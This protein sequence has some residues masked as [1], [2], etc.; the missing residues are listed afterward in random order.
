MGNKNKSQ[1]L[2]RRRSSWLALS[3]IIFTVSG[4]GVADLK[5][6]NLT[7]M[8]FP[9]LGLGNT[10]NSANPNEPN[11]DLIA[12]NLVHTL[13][14]LPSL[15]PL[16]TVVQMQPSSSEFDLQTKLALANRG[17]Q[18]DPV[19]GSDDEFVVTTE[20]QNSS[21]ATGRYQLYTVN[22]GEVS[23][24]RAYEVVEGL[25]VPVSAQLVT[26]TTE[27]AISINDDIFESPDNRLTAVDFQS[28]DAPD[29]P[30]AVKVAAVTAKTPEPL[31]V[32]AEPPAVMWRLQLPIQTCRIC[33]LPRR[34]VCKNRICT[35][36]ANPIMWMCSMAMKMS[37]RAS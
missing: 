14:Q 20:I 16:V 21:T 6:P 30:E 19:S 11:S 15:N 7:E 13:V 29:V 17:Y 36:L 18:I 25:T 26:G 5:A 32:D 34:R 37:S 2:A 12:A 4:C 3:L 33:W 35:K 10:S 1:L 28:L 9:N 8:N 31:I 22:I 23:V 27:R 24:E